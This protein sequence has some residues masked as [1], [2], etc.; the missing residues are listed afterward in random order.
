M[1]YPFTLKSALL[2]VNPLSDPSCAKIVVHTTGWALGKEPI[3]LDPKKANRITIKI[4]R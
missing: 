2:T 3:S 4:G 1:K